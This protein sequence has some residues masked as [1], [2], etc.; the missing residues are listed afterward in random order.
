MSN[1]QNAFEEYIDS[2]KKALKEGGLCFGRRK[3]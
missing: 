2:A 1:N 3:N